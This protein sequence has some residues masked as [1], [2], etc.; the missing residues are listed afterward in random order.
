MNTLAFARTNATT[1]EKYAMDAGKLYVG[2]LLVL[3]V[4]DCEVLDETMP[5]TYDFTD[6][7]S[8]SCMGGQGNLP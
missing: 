2:M 5:I 3:H 4:V 8:R 6:C 7:P 1:Q